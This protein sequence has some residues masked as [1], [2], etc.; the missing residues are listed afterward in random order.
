MIQELLQRA[1][2]E[3][4]QFESSDEL[5]SWLRSQGCEERALFV[6]VQINFP[7]T[8]SG[9]T[10]IYEFTVE[11]ED[12]V[13][14]ILIPREIDLSQLR[15]EEC[16]YVD[17]YDAEHF[18]YC[19]ECREDAERTCLEMAQGITEAFLKATN[20][21]EE[22]VRLKGARTLPESTSASMFD[23]IPLADGRGVFRKRV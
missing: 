4:L 10:M 23:D 2:Q 15:G 14:T 1:E 6:P 3:N 7:P 18:L 5:H 12:L 16:G 21:A 20:A 17:Y 9:N 19:T 8:R 13:Y 11:Y 22:R